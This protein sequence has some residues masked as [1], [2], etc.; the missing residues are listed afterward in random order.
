MRQ[1][2]TM[3]ALDIEERW[4][5][6]YEL[7]FAQI[8]TPAH[9]LLTKLGFASISYGM[10]TFC[11]LTCICLVVPASVCCLFPPISW[12]VSIYL[13]NWCEAIQC[14]RPVL[15]NIQ[16]K[17]G[18]QG[19][20]SNHIQHAHVLSVWNMRECVYVCMCACVRGRLR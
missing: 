1:T 12:G 7:P 3:W 14:W 2:H 16:R 13:L 19:E 8:S 6:A 10:I 4:S 18:I 20:R 11:V 5:S 17:G 9:R 15:E